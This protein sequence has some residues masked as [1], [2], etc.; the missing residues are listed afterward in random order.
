MHPPSIC[1]RVAWL[2]AASLVP[3]ISLAQRTEYQQQDVFDSVLSL[4]SIQTPL[5]N[6]DGA[7]VQKQE[8]SNSDVATPARSDR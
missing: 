1:T 5:F 6:T 8:V 3:A 2:A 4:F 7:F